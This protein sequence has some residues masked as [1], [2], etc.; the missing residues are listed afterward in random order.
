MLSLRLRSSVMYGRGRGG[1]G[2]GE[3]EGDRENIFNKK[4]GM[5]SF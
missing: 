1:G 5:V 3:I 2:T 4:G